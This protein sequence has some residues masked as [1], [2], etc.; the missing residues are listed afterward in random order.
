MLLIRCQQRRLGDVG[1]AQSLRQRLGFMAKDREL[2]LALDLIDQIIG[3]IKT[4]RAHVLRRPQ[5][6][7]AVQWV[8]L[9]A[10]QYLHR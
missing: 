5:A 3:L 9:V 6:G 4:L 10:A 7:Q 1:D 8:V 2:Y